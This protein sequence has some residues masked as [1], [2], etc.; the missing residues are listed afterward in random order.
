MSA[1]TRTDLYA[2]VTQL[3]ISDLDKGIRPWLKPWRAGTKAPVTLPLRH[4][5]SPYRGVNVLLL[6]SA[7]VS[8]GCESATWM[9]YKQAKE[10]KAQVKKGEHGSV[11][12]YADRMVRSEVTE[13]GGEVEREVPFLRGNLVFN[14]DQIAG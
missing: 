4:N 7:A 1:S 9:T 3:I 10:L 13:E 8:R 5:G 6:W 12:V 11:I 14:V 2:R